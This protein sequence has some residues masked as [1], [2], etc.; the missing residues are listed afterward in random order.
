MAQFPI[1]PSISP[2]TI[3]KTWRLA[4]LV[5]TAGVLLWAFYV[6]FRPL[7]KRE[8][9]I[10][11]GT[12]GSAYTLTAERYRTVLARYG[13][14]L[15]L[16]PTSGAIE[17]LDRLK[18][19]SATG[20]DAGFVQAGTTT[21]QESPDLVSLGT[22][23]YE[24]LWIFSRNGAFRDLLK[25]RAISDAGKASVPS[26]RLSI[27]PV[28][29]ATRPLT[30][31]LLALNQIDTSNLQLSAFAPEEAARRLIAGELDAVAILAAW[32]TPAVQQLLVAPDIELVSWKRADAYVALYPRF[33]KLILPEGVADI[34]KNRPPTDVSLIGS[35]ASLAVRRDLHPAL[36]YLLIQ[37]AVDVHGRPRIF[38]RDNEFPAPET[39]DLPLS[40]E[41]RHFYRAG[42]SV[43]QRTLPFWLA[44]LV[45]RLAIIVLPIA[46]VLYP[47]WSWLPRFYRWQ[48][49]R[50][51]YRLYGELRLIED[52]LH[53]ST[54]PAERAQMIARIDE[55]ERRVL[56]VKLP[57]SFS[58]MSFNLMAHIRA[59][60]ASAGQAT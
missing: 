39:I 29:G 8:L 3:P 40:D 19:S 7:P 57:S 9:S 45:Q 4:V 47:F 60:R 5:V 42:P 16:V 46:G 35:K 58:E 28:G 18:D 30:L 44:E 53:R 48:M 38:Q 49:Q 32:D 31:E 17:N 27:G 12:G 59:A 34:A 10:A 56:E 55:L 15:R 2:K 41:A 14:R 6:V 20:V 43:L 26:A 54:D 22:V 36:Q 13:V 51:I 1:P 11:T 33:T 50:R 24:P 23:F 52:T 21:E 37:A 25:D